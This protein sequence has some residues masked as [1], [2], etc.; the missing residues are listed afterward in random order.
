MFK[1]RCRN[2]LRQAS[3]VPARYCVVFLVVLLIVHS[4]WSHAVAPAHLDAIAEEIGNVSYMLKNEGTARNNKP[5]LNHAGNQIL[6]C[7]SSEKGMG[8][9]LCDVDGDKRKMI[10]EEKEICFGGGPH[11]V[12]KLFPWSP[13]DRWIVYTH[14]GPGAE[15]GNDDC[16]NESLLTVCNAESGEEAATFQ[17]PFGQVAG[18]DWLSADTFAFSSGH[19]L[20][21]SLL[22]VV[23]R[24]PDGSWRQKQLDYTAPAETTNSRVGS[25]VAMSS[26]TVVWLQGNCFW[27]LDVAS[28]APTKI[29]ALPKGHNFTSF[30]YSK[31]T[32]KFLISCLEPRNNGCSLWQFPLDDPKALSKLDSA[33]GI[34]QNYWN[35]AKWIN[36]GRGYAYIA[37]SQE[38]SVSGLVVKNNADTHPNILFP[39]QNIQYLMVSPD[40]QSLFVCGEINDQLGSGIWEYGL[41]S[42]QSRC[43]VPGSEKPMQYSKDI[44][45]QF[46]DYKSVNGIVVYPPAN[47]DPAK[48]KKYP[49][50]ITSIGFKAAQPY[51]SQYAE[52]V[53]NAGAYFVD[54]DRPWDNK[55]TGITV[56]ETTMYDFYNQMAEIPNID[57]DKKKIFI[58]SN[59][60]QSV[61]LMHM[62]AQHPGLCKGVIMFVPGNLSDPSTLVSI[63]SQPLKILVSDQGGSNEEYLKK[64]QEDAYKTGIAMDY[65]I[66]PGT[67]HEFIAQQSQR[68]RIKAM[69][70]FIFD[71]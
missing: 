3:I 67:P 18:L 13:D 11:G 70:H 2:L 62:L 58:L 6:F 8:V 34:H 17:I 26:N 42:K 27:M 12:L 59:S 29:L 56:W 32:R 54:V 15:N 50:V 43:V 9:F 10:F 68:T 41:A 21:S 48:H 49:I 66:H 23:S 53:A 35:D 61:G 39:D 33:T 63:K 19:S 40:G 47:Y 4:L 5:Q 28:N 38:K 20:S 69:L 1:E 51:I 24:Q 44:Q 22:C 71:D 64:Y 55:G 60:A 16:P 25:F 46:L 36:G 7:Q 65:L 14:Q 45:P 52:A 57:F 37:P 31:E 30:D